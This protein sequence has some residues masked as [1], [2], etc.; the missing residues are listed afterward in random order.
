[1]RKLLFTALLVA[2][3]LSATAQ[4]QDIIDA[5]ADTSNQSS[6]PYLQPEF[7]PQFPGGK[8]ALIK[9]L[10]ENIKYPKLAQK[11]GVGGKVMMTFIIDTKGK[12]TEI[13]AKDCKIE[14]FSSPRF[15]QEPRI[16]QKELEEKFALEFAKEAARVIRKMPNW[17][18]GTLDGKPVR[19]KY[20]LPITFKLP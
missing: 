5:K 9:I 8:D 18:P 15:S 2:I 3:S 19:V 1:M 20:T 14:N 12:P 6:L 11:Y 7:Q 17:T 16:V 10:S 4:S 13:T